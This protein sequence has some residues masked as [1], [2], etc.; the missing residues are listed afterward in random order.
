[1]CDIWKAN[2]D[3]R[4]I[5]VEELIPHLAAFKALGVKHVA[6]SGGEALMHPNLWK[7]CAMLK[8]IG[9]KISLLST[10][11]LVKNNAEEI[12]AHCDDLILSLDGD[13]EVHNRIRN[14]PLAFE[15]LAEGIQAIKKINPLFRI[16]GRSVI[17]KKNFNS[18]IETVNAA[19]EIQLD[20]ISFLPADVSSFAFNR[21]EPWAE[22]KKEEVALTLSEAETLEL[23]MKKSF[24]TFSAEYRSGFIAESEEK[25][26]SFVQHFRAGQG[27]GNFPVKRCNAPWVSSVIESN[28]DVMPCFF[29]PAYGNIHK[30]NFTDII[31]SR[32]AVL[33]RKQLDVNRNAICERCVCS[34][35]VGLTQRF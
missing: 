1:M 18:F 10:G 4:E 31:N 23:I 6:L 5:A 15:K 11:L 9:A 30:E 35:R 26:L 8:S 34:L 7:L 21:A 16:T 2:H 27:Q 33:F 3:K 22:E 20:Q 17:Q 25:L 32:D 13:R 14:I 12:V 19:R 28:G 24:Q 29:L